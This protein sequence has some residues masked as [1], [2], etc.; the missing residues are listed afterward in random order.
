MQLIKKVN[1]AVARL[2]PYEPGR[3]IEEVAREQGLDPAEIVKL[4]SNESALGPS[5]L[6]MAAIQRDLG[7]IYRYPDGGAYVLRNKLAA[8]HGVTREQVI[9]GNGSNEIL[10]FIGHCFLGP[11][12]SAV[13]SAHAFVIYKLLS[14][15]FGTRAIE[16]PMAPGLVHDPEAILAAIAPDTN[17]VFICNPNNPTGT[18]METGAL[19]HLLQSIPENVLVV[20]DEAYAEVALS[21][22][23]PTMEL[24]RQRPNILVCRTFSKAYGLAGLRVGYAV[25]QTELVSAL[26]RARQPFNVNLLAQTA[27]VAA[28]DDQAFVDRCRQVYAAARDQLEAGCQ[29]LGLD[30]IRSQANFMLIKVGD[31]QGVTEQLQSR[32]VIV[33]PMG[34]YQLPEYIRVS[35]GQEEENIRFLSAL[36][37]V[38][39][40]G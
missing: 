33:R 20:M 32:G 6:A 28:L 7:E 1:P 16:V 15:M 39:T 18:M 38:I 25:G 35:F 17:V 19:M 3:P 5:P 37:Q 27:A 8:L 9:L 30:F 12:S 11:D 34:G 29:A 40:T 4:A 36:G 13:F 23:P 31:G 14:A 2:N 26:Q 10:E 21:P 22:M 24:A